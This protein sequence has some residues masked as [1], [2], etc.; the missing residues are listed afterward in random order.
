M[1]MQPIKLELKHVKSFSELNAEYET[2]CEE[3]M[4]RMQ[5][6][7]ASKINDE[8][9]IIPQIAQENMLF[10]HN[11]N[12]QQLK[13]IAKYHKLK[14]SGNKSQLM[15]RIY[16]FLCLSGFAIKIQ[17]V[18]RG[19]LQRRCNALHGPGWKNKTICTNSIDFLTMDLLLDLPDTQFFSYKD[20]DGFIYGFDT[21]SFYN[22]I[23]KSENVAKNPYNR[24]MISDKVV[25]DF[26]ILM[27]LSRTLK[28]PILTQMK[29]E[30]KSLS[31]TKTVELLIIDVFQKIDALGNYSNPKWF[32]DLSSLQIFRFLRHLLDIWQYRAHLTDEMRI[33][34]CPPHGMP[35]RR[36]EFSPNLDI[37]RKNAVVIMEK[38]V[39][40]ANDKDSKCLGAYYVLG[41]LTLVSNDAATS[42]N[43]LY[44]AFEY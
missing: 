10:Q 43:V 41:A 4:K 13:N 37:M 35:F 36:V 25:S 3:R 8:N 20:E 40:S 32:M 2:M 17:R 21:I 39:N 31:E 42:M 1:Q 34:I 30:E 6:K 23:Y 16:T 26:R 18:F 44:Q 9:L 19:H 12:I 27:R 38:M 22:L 11:Y 15:A 29:A 24:N 5:D 14:V 7:N 28:S 33:T